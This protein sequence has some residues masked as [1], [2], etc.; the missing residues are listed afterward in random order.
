MTLHFGTDGVRGVAITEITPTDAVTLGA[1]AVQALGCSRLL[2]GR[3]TRRSGSV[4]EAAV[5]AGA[6]AA[7]ARVELLGVLPT[8]ALAHHA[9]VEG[10]AAAMITVESS[11]VG[12]HQRRE[13]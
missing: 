6:A 3:D 1:A 4:L 9:Q 7:G 8:P 11:A 2:L 13:R 12:I 10:A 5:A